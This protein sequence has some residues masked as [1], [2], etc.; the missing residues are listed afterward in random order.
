MISLAQEN[1]EGQKTA[2]KSP[3]FSENG[4]CVELLKG[5]TTATTKDRLFSLATLDVIPHKME[6]LKFC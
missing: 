6:S 3:Q 5:F 4:L 1:T 2:G